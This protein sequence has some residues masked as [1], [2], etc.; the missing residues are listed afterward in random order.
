[1][2][3]LRMKFTWIAATFILATGYF[4]SCTKDDQVVLTTDQTNSSTDLISVKTSTAPTI[5]GTIDAGWANA[6][7]LEI[8]PAVPDPGNNLFTG[9]I[10]EVYPITLRSMY[11]D[12]NVYFLAEYADNTKSVDVATWY[13]DPNSKRWA[14]EPTSKTFDV[15]GVLTRRD[16]GEDKIAMLWN[17]DNST[18]KF[19]TQTCYG[20]CHVFTPYMDYSVTPA[21]YKSNASSGNHYTNG[22][23]EKIDMWWGHLSRDVIFSQM[24]DNYQDWAGGPAIT[25]LVGGNANGR[26]VD[27]LVVSGA[28]TTWPYRPTYTTAAPQ[29]AANNRQSLKLDGTGATVTVPM[30]IKP[31]ASNYY[32]I[33][34]SDTLAG[35]TAVKITGVSST[36]VLT[37][38]GGS[39]DPN[40][41]ADYQRAGDPVTG[42]DGAKCF[43]SYIA[44]PLIGGRADIS[45]SAVYTGTGWI[46]E[47]KRK[48]KT[49]DVLKQDVDFSSL[50]DQQ[51]GF[52]IWDRSN[53][54][55]AIQPGLVL[56]FKK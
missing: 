16:F 48:L 8:S 42:G 40:G 56:K 53:Y 15:N 26:H 3:L 13:F 23:N 31:G 24:D 36:G 46:V 43:P 10:G 25:N 39:I 11:D 37:Y 28:S 21:V 55:H 20:S 44:S 27:D 35:G 34:A 50:G 5:D 12:E 52:A 49:S 7:K 45:C 6:T 32:Y 38:A 1:M 30:W 14:Q 17:I 18:P 54:Q 19:V 29:G 22:V 33:L 47:Y 51:F 4:V 41:D 2:K 9:Y